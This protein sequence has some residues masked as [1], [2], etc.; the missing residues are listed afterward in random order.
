MLLVPIA[1]G[2]VARLR[3]TDGAQSGEPLFMFRC[4]FSFWGVGLVVRSPLHLAAAPC[5]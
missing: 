3:G 2:R 4:A 1:V 5:R